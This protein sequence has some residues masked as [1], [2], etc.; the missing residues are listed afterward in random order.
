[1]GGQ[2]FTVNYKSE[3]SLSIGG[4]PSRNIKHWNKYLGEG[5]GNYQLKY[6]NGKCH[7]TFPF[8]LY[9]NFYLFSVYLL[10]KE[11]PNND[12]NYNPEKAKRSQLYISKIYASVCTFTPQY[13]D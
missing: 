7:L 6:K 12:N 2:E 9:N 8:A 13:Y 4:E 1:M 11:N 10:V 5:H 3:D